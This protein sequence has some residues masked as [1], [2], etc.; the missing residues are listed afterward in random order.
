MIVGKNDA[1]PF[2]HV[3][4]LSGLR[5]ILAKIDVPASTTDSI[6]TFPPIKESLSCIPA[7]EVVPVV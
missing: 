7:S 3:D 1:S 5:G 2:V 4:G 6:S